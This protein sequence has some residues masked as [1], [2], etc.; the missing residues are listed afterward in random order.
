MYFLDNGNN[1]VKRTDRASN[2]CNLYSFLFLPAETDSVI[3][4]LSHWL[5]VCWAPAK[6]FDLD[7]RDKAMVYILKVAHL[8][9]GKTNKWWGEGKV[10]GSG[11]GKVW[12]SGKLNNMLKA[13]QLFYCKTESYAQTSLCTSTIACCFQRAKPEFPMKTTEFVKLLKYKWGS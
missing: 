13:T 2:Q 4:R 9:E 11:E 1:R 5:S 6:H 8:L 3:F 10:W 7:N 12:G